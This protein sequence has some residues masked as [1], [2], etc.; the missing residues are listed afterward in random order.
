MK[1]TCILLL[2]LSLL[3]SAAGCQGQSAP[4]A[5]SGT[6]EP[7][8]SAEAPLPEPSEPY[9]AYEA[10]TLP[11]IENNEEFSDHIVAIW[12]SWLDCYEGMEPPELE[13]VHSKNMEELME[14]IKEYGNFCYVRNDE[15]Q[16]LEINSYDVKAFGGTTMEASEEYMYANTSY[17]DVPYS[18]GFTFVPPKDDFSRRFGCR[19]G[20]DYGYYATVKG[21]HLGDVRIAVN[22]ICF[23]GKSVNFETTLPENYTVTVKLDEALS[24]SALRILTITG[25]EADAFLLTRTGSR[26]EL[27]VRQPCEV[28]IASELRADIYLTQTVPAETRWYVE[29]LLAEPDKLVTGFLP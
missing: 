1:R 23:S 11:P 28:E 27:L 12:Y 7:A 17:W 4:P 13:D 22:G 2:V 16:Q 26:F 10:Y 25:S 3:L 9:D 6:A 8:R 5:D 29:D 14:W 24:D 19:W 15:G 18:S 20:L 21:D